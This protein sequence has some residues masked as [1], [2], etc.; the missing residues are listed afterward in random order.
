MTGPGRGLG[1][2]RQNSRAPR[3]RGQFHRSLGRIVAWR[4]HPGGPD[5]DHGARQLGLA[6][7]GGR[8]RASQVHITANLSLFNRRSG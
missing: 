8:E 1:G 2:P 4:P 7:R 6:M 3:G 5:Q